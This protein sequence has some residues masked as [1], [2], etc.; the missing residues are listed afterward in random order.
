MGDNKKSDKGK[1]KGK[2]KGR[3]A[4]SEYPYDER[5]PLEEYEEELRSLQVQLIKLQRWIKDENRRLVII[6]EG[7]DAAGKGG[8]IKRFTEH[9]NP[10]GARVV[11]LRAPDET[12]RGQWYFQRYVTQLPTA[13]EIVFFDRS[14]YNR[15]GVEPVMGFCTPAQYRE[16]MR[17]V[18]GF[19]RM[20]VESEVHLIKLWFAIERK[21]QRRRFEA[22]KTDP[23]KQ[24]KLS[25]T[26]LAAIDK[27]DDY[28]VARDRM[29]YFSHTRDAP[30]AFILAD[31]KRRARIHAIRYVLNLVPYAEKDPDVAR[32]PDPKIVM[33]PDA[34]DPDPDEFDFSASMMK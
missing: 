4:G 10:R 33:E 16:F 11:A 20:L 34:A 2:G 22:R 24:W 31:D 15:G 5:M 13:G 17:Q 29:F 6:F 26:D 21:E 28:S 32:P 12:E 19:E 7:R 3:F 1:A 14:W 9:L 23:L 30:W 25:P 8:T 18:A 27:W